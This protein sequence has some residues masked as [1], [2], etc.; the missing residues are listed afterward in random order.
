MRT[1]AGPRLSILSGFLRGEVDGVREDGR[2][3]SDCPSFLGF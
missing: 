2:Q 1:A 3:V